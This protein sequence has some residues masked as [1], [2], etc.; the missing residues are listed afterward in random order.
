[1]ERF[2]KEDRTDIMLK[3]LLL[4]E[5]DIEKY[6]H[7]LTDLDTTQE[8]YTTQLTTGFY[9]NNC[10]ERKGTACSEF[11]TDSRGFTAK[12]TLQKDNL[13]FFSI[14]YD[15][16]WSATVDGK[17]VEIVKANVGFMAVPV[18]GDGAEHTIRFTYY[19]PGLT[20]GAVTTL[21]GLLC[22]AALV[23]V[24]RR[25]RKNHPIAE[26]ETLFEEHLARL[27]AEEQAR[28]EAEELARQEELAQL[29]QEALEAEA[30]S[31]QEQED[32]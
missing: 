32:V 8:D 27:E 11:V 20:A 10:L 12:T 17:A 5:E 1:M 18:T 31:E 29:A 7:L 4:S 19:T 13:V 28:R 6:G 16:G 21:F 2:D 9:F 25:Y 24:V 26:E 15:D 14:P 30:P 23:L 3:A 22:A